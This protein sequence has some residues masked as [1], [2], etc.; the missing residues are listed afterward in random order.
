VRA[1]FPKRRG[2]VNGPSTVN[3][4]KL[5]HLGGGFASPTCH[6]PGEL[7]A[8]RTRDYSLARFDI[9]RKM[10]S[11]GTVPHGAVQ[12]AT[13]CG[14]EVWALSRRGLVYRHL[15]Q[16]HWQAVAAPPQPFV[17][18]A[19]GANHN[20][21]GL[22]RRGVLYKLAARGWARLDG[23]KYRAMRFRDVSTTCAG[24]VT[25]IDEQ[26]RVRLRDETG[27]WRLL[28]KAPGHPERVTAST[29]R[30]LVIA[31][32]RDGRVFSFGPKG[33]KPFTAA[34]LNELSTS[35]VGEVC[36]TWGRHLYVA[37]ASASAPPADLARRAWQS[38]TP[39][40]A[41]TQNGGLPTDPFGASGNDNAAPGIGS[42]GG[43]VRARG[44]APA[45]PTFADE[46][47]AFVRDNLPLA[48]TDFQAMAPTLPGSHLQP[49]SNVGAR[50]VQDAPVVD[51]LPSTR[52][53]YEADHASNGAGDG[54]PENLR[55]GS[56]T[57][58]AMARNNVKHVDFKQVA[59]PVP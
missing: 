18:I 11:M 2:R 25:A 39:E 23:R 10:V 53:E 41:D 33:W 36:G 40:P 50:R 17:R 8:V 1:R 26:F 49:F 55:P 45:T 42:H 52:R 7:W 44:F 20:V 16:D 13:T 5:S 9:T 34:R 28:P 47:R 15:G 58:D 38:L 37:W 51:P 35:S 48:V 57:A 32:M 6:A 54:S 43:D 59:N 4:V 14:D 21:L 27:R 3:G 29:S 31:T 19:A 22:T 46:H 30:G 24:V 12:V 56:L